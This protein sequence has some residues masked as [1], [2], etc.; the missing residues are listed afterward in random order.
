M[1]VRAPGWLRSRADAWRSGSVRAQWWLAA[2]LVLLILLSLVVSLVNHDL[3]PLTAYFLWLLIARIL[4]SFRPL[5]VVA[6]VNA[7]AGSL[8]IC[9]SRTGCNRSAGWPSWSSCWP[10]L[11]VLYVAG[12]LRSAL[13]S[14]LSEALLGNLRDRLQAQGRMPPL[15]EGWQSQTAMLASDGVSYAGDFLVADLREDR[16]AGG[17]PGRRLRQ[18]HR[19]RAGGAAVRGRAGRADRG[20]AARGAVPCGQRLPAPPERRRVLRHRGAPARRP[21]ERRLPDHQRRPPARA[22]AWTCPAAS[23]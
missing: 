10:S 18:G 14:T 9:C 15:P 22:A 6:T 17:D 11:L 21:R 4:L 7:I 23:G 20:A 1:A 5:V 16:A 3:M 8:A 19:R 13:P 2:T 12:R